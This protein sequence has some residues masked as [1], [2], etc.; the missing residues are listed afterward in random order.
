[1]RKGALVAASMLAACS[2]PRPPLPMGA[3]AYRVIPAP[4]G[5]AVGDYRIGALDELGITVF[6]EPQLS[7]EKLKV[8]AGGN[9]LF[10]LIGAVHAAG[11]TTQ[12][13]AAE[14]ARRL[15]ARY[16]RDPQVTV[17]V[18]ASVSQRVTVEGSVGA[19][20]VYEI[21][22]NAT[23]LEAIARAQSPTTTAKLNQVIVFRMTD[24]Q[25][26]GAVFDLKR[27][28]AGIDPD[29]RIL[30]GDTVVVGFSQVRGALRDFLSVTP[31]LAI[32]R[33]F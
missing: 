26:T 22:G 9:L 30:G 12:E 33:P 24:G 27:I 20:G 32:F 17:A 7:L 23:L 8:D 16:V 6:R 10:P 13:L 25:R 31:L 2:N 4:T 5:V 15:D 21:A 18:T 3:D 1:M 28:R 11:K 19:P 29:P 14:I